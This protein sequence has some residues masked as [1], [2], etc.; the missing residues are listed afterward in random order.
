MT[1]VNDTIIGGTFV[2]ISFS[3]LRTSESGKIWITTTID[4]LFPVSQHKLKI[5]VKIKL[6]I[7]QT[8]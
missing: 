4:A 5:S 2:G 7:G 6:Q 8:I 1:R 3:F